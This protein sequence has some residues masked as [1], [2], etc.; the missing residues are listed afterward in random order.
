VNGW[1]VLRLLAGRWSAVAREAGR[2]PASALVLRDALVDTA[3]DLGA[4]PLDQTRRY[5]VV[6]LRAE[7]TARR[8]RRGDFLISARVH[9]LKIHPCRGRYA[10]Q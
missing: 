6:I 4:D 1:Q 2:W 10:L 5:R 3:V 8:D 7:V 9:E